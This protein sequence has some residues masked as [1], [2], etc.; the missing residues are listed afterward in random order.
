MPPADTTSSLYKTNIILLSV[1]YSNYKSFFK[2]YLRLFRNLKFF[3]AADSIFDNSFLNCIPIFNQFESTNSILTEYGISIINNPGPASNSTDFESVVD[4]KKLETLLDANILSDQGD[5]SS[6]KSLL[7]N[8]PEQ[9]LL[10][11]ITPKTNTFLEFEHL[12]KAGEDFGYILT[13]TN[14][15][16]EQIVLRSIARS[17]GLADEHELPEDQIEDT[18]FNRLLNADVHANLILVNNIHEPISLKGSKWEKMLFSNP[19]QE[20]NIK[21]HPLHPN[22][23]NTIPSFLYAPE[24]IELWEGGLGLTKNVIRSS[25]DCLMRRQIG[26]P[27]LP[28]RDFKVPFCLAC[29]N[30]LRSRVLELGRK[31]NINQAEFRGFILTI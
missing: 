20:Y 6:I 28:I 27:N 24:E 17:M 10:F 13:P 7:I 9:Y 18:Y 4:F 3:L 12:P 16:W 14:G 11:L 31:N 1:G 30:Y 25:H 22:P 5:K 15:Y 29:E 23:D 2:D 8:H 21:S 19:T 26:D